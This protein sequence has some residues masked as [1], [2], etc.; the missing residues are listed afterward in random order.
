[1]SFLV[2]GHFQRGR[3]DLFRIPTEIQTFIERYR[4]SKALLEQMVKLMVS[5][6]QDE[7]DG[8]GR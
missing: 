8:S 4:K 7:G 3:R 6:Q 2:G 5:G 1:M